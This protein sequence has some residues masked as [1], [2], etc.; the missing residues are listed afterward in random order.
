MLTAAIYA[1][2]LQA[3]RYVRFW[4]WDGQST[5]LFL[6]RAV[7]VVC[8]LLLPIRAAARR[9][10]IPVPVTVIHT[11]Y[12]ED[13]HNTE[14]EQVLGQLERQPGRHLVIVHYRP[15]HDVLRE[16]VFNAADING[17]KVVWARD[18]GAAQNK[19]VVSYFKDRRVWSLEPDEKPPK[20]SPYSS[21]EKGPTSIAHLE[22]RAPSA[23]FK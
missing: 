5:G 15:D 3:M 1:I 4:K 19:E 12:T 10:H 2:V 20:L 11:C 18:M 21:I 7:P 6:V 23:G 16:W 14:R 22:L 9:L 13:V 8:L 17:S